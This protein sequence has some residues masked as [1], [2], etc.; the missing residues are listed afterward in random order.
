MVGPSMELSADPCGGISSDRNSS[1]G[2]NESA[3][4]LLYLPVS[5]H[6]GHFC[7]NS[8]LS[9]K[10]G[11]TSFLSSL[12]PLWDPSKGGKSHYLSLYLKETSM[13][14]QGGTP[15]NGALRDATRPLASRFPVDAVP[16]PQIPQGNTLFG[17]QIW[18]FLAVP[19]PFLQM[20]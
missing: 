4:F 12:F 2:I 6:C 1:W 18:D 11:P 17:C 9:S 19:E 7:F 16:Y 10:V 20:P 13:L 8:K 3:V 15:K 5:S 14:S